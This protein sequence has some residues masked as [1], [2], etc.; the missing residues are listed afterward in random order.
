MMGHGAPSFTRRA[1]GRGF[2]LPRCLSPWLIVLFTSYCS[3]VGVWTCQANG[4]V[5][6]DL[7]WTHRS[8]WLR[9]AVGLGD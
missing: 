5:E 9:G 2:I 3:L 6:S 4:V 1:S 7:A 8:G